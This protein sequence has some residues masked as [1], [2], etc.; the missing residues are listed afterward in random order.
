MMHLRTRDWLELSYRPFML[1]IHDRCPRNDAA[2]YFLPV[3]LEGLPNTKSRCPPPPVLVF[4]LETKTLQ[5]QQSS[6]LEPEYP[7]C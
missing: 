5:M 3:L 1:Y 6:L 7:V 4:Q 2:S